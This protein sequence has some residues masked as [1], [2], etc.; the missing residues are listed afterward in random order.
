MWHILHQ[1]LLFKTV[2]FYKVMELNNNGH[3]ITAGSAIWWSVVKCSLYYDGECK[4]TALA[5]VVNKWPLT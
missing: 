5:F 4:S 3:K 1:W 2:I